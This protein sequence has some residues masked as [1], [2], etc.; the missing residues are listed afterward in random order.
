MEGSS[1]GFTGKV[2][3]LQETGGC[4][5]ARRSPS[6]ERRTNAMIIDKNETPQELAFTLTFPQLRQAHEIYKKHCFF[7]D[8]IGQ[9]EDR[10]QDRI[11]LC[12]LPYQTLEHETDIL[13][14]AYELYEKLEDSN[15]SYHVTM[16]NVID[17]IEKQILNGELRPH[18]EPV[19]RVVLVMEDGIVTASYTNASSIQAEVIKLDKEYDSTEEREAVYASLDHDPELCKCECH[20]TWPGYEGENA[21]KEAA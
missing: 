8:F 14:T 9:C 10:R 17:E 20:I 12:N 1:P 16:E 15:V 21:G 5:A 13:C 4:C 6:S 11:G 19:P 7:Q 2:I 3:D 18:P